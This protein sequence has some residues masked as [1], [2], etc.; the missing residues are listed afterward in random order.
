M[1][2]PIP[3][4]SPYHY[5]HPAHRPLVQIKEPT[6]SKIELTEKELAK[7]THILQ[8][9][10]MSDYRKE[11]RSRT[12]YRNVREVFRYPEFIIT[13]YYDTVKLLERY[14]EKCLEQEKERLKEISS[15][16]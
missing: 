16:E 14:C 7:L 3:S 2:D 5:I 6:I 11:L 15:K 8:S 12:D 9:D 1:S 13:K 10:K 4:P